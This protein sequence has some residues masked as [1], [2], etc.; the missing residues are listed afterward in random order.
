MMGAVAQV[1]GH[2]CNKVAIWVCAYACTLTLQ[3]VSEP[4]LLRYMAS[5]DF[6]AMCYLR[7]M[8]EDLLICSIMKSIN[9]QGDSNS[10]RK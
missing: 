1:L 2:D 7:Y 9:F 5:S 4:I 6:S 3:A 8:E 10:D